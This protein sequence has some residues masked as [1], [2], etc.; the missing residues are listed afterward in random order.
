MFGSLETSLATTMFA[1]NA[2]AI[3]TREMRRM[4]NSEFGMT[5]V[6]LNE[7]RQLD[8]SG[9]GADGSMPTTRRGDNSTPRPLVTDQSS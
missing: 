3:E 9:L 2:D 1:G 8:V 6:G 5:D 4:I 7:H